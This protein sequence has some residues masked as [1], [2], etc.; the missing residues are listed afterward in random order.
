VDEHRALAQALRRCR[1]RVAVSGYR[2]DLLDTLYN[3]WRRVDA[4]VR[5]VHSVK[6]PR[7]ESLWMNY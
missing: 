5:T 3:D 2:C 7:Q 4:P 1:G 6:Q